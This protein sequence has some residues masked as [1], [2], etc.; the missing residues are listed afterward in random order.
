[1]VGQVEQEFEL[2]QEGLGDCL[3]KSTRWAHCWFCR[4][5][6][7]VLQLQALSS[8]SANLLPV[9]FHNVQALALEGERRVSEFE[10]ELCK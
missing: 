9:G 7:S 1:M 6:L 10:G 5:V 4:S 8:T 3:V 2:V